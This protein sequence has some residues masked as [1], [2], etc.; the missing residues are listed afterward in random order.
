[1]SR[2]ITGPNCRRAELALHVVDG[3]IDDVLPVLGQEGHRCRASGSRPKVP[4]CRA[5]LERFAPLFDAP[6]RRFVVLR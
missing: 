6:V 4:V 2:T 3:L 1:M 5:R